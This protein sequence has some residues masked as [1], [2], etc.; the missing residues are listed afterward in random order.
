MNNLKDKIEGMIDK[1]KSSSLSSIVSDPVYI[2]KEP[3]QQNKNSNKKQHVIK[4]IKKKPEEHKLPMY[5]NIIIKKRKPK[6]KISKKNFS[7]QKEQIEK[8]ENISSKNNPPQHKEVT[9]AKPKKIII[10]LK[11]DHINS[12]PENKKYAHKKEMPKSEEI[13]P[14]PELNQRVPLKITIKHN[15]KESNIDPKEDSHRIKIENNDLLPIKEIYES[16]PQKKVII[17][18]E[19]PKIEKQK[20]IKIEKSSNNNIQKPIVKYETHSSNELY[21]PKTFIKKEPQD[22]SLIKEEKAHTPY[23]KLKLNKENLNPNNKE[24]INNSIIKRICDKDKNDLK[25]AKNEND[26]RKLFK[27]KECNIKRNIKN[28][29][30]IPTTKNEMTLQN[31]KITNVHNFNELS[32]KKMIYNI[33]INIRKKKKDQIHKVIQIKNNEELQQNLIPSNSNNEFIS[34]KDIVSSYLNSIPIYSSKR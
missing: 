27:N 9:E 31:N 21:T 24:K 15:T 16:N 12:K 30:N 20:A 7:P 22:H 17:I 34:K 8:T 32:P 11:H 3:D 1:L 2:K 13:K 19:K 14:K 25:L 10:K 29:I 23:S 6:S 26:E 4:T 33:N 28:L 18:K 5:K